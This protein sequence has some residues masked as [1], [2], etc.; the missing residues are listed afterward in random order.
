MNTESIMTIEETLFM[1]VTDFLL[2]MDD[3]FSLDT[4]P[5]MDSDEDVHRGLDVLNIYAGMTDYLKTLS[6]YAKVY[7]RDLKRK[8][9]EYK[10]DYEDMVDRENIINNKLDAIKLSYQA[11]NKCITIYVEEKRASQNYTRR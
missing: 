11:V 10:T 6:S 5:R 8:G 7:A 9:K 1:S 3:H 4:P 2:W